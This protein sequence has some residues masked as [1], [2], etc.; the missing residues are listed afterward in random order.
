MKKIFLLWL[1]GL[2]TFGAFAASVTL[3]AK[4]EVLCTQGCRVTDVTAGRS[5]G[6]LSLAFRYEPERD[7]DALT[8]AVTGL[9]PRNWVLQ[10]DGWTLGK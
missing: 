5:A 1:V 6:N 7:G 4:G 10:S 8:L 9:Y 3:T 2:M